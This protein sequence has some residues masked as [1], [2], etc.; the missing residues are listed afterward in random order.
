MK[1]L[2]VLCMVAIC[3]CVAGTTN[4]NAGIL[5]YD[6][7]NSENGGNWQL[8]YDG[9]ANWT[10]TGGT[11][12]LIGGNSGWNWYTAT[13]GLYVDM[14]GSTG[15]AGIM[16]LKS[17]VLTLGPGTYTLQFD[18]AGNKRTPQ[19][20]AVHVQVNLG[21][22]FSKQYT[23]AWDA[24]FTSYVETFTVLAGDAPASLSFEGIGTDNIGMLLDNVKVSSVPEPATMLLLGTGLVGVAAFRRKLKK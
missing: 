2:R 16:T 23:L 8:N 4:A 5:L 9:F 20:D 12:D 17:S 21:S 7:F 19:Q 15:N 18:L 1:T 11:V 10:V 13:N 24:P 6:D 22:V 3:L 14:D